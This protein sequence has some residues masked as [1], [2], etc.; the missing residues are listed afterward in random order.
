MRVWLVSLAVLFGLAEL[1][2]WVKGFMLPLPIYV[3]GG[4]FLAIASNYEKGICS[5][6]EPESPTFEQIK[7]QKATLVN[8]V[9]AVLDGE[10]FNPPSFPST[11]PENPDNSS[12]FSQELDTGK[13]EL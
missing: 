2:Q 1:Y 3:L 8:P 10:I 7:S 12:D 9:N 6:F 5:F 11:A 13:F 4:A